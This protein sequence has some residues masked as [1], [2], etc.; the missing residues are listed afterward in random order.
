[1]KGNKTPAF[2]AVAGDFDFWAIILEKTWAKIHTTY[3][4]TEK[5]MHAEVM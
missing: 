5:G 3:G 4:L 1:M 2:S